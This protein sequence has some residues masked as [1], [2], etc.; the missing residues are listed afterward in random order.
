MPRSLQKTVLPD[1]YSSFHSPYENYRIVIPHV[2]CFSKNTFAVFLAFSGHKNIRT[3]K[4]ARLNVTGEQSVAQRDG[5]QQPFFAQHNVPFLRKG[6][7]VPSFRFALEEEISDSR[8][9]CNHQ[10][11]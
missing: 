9:N 6:A 8:Q 3:M 2:R 5:C 10:W 1:S 11:K 7:P 4:R